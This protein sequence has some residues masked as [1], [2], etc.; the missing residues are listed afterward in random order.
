MGGISSVPDRPEGGRAAS[1][2]AHRTAG[3]DSLTP[4]LT[5]TGAGLIPGAPKI[6]G[7]PLADRARAEIVGDEKALVAELAKVSHD[8]VVKEP[9]EQINQ[10]G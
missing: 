1:A 4:L 2:R 8:V 10:R 6:V 5:Y 9:N 7:K 3:P